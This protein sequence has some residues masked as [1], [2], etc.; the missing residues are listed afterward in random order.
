[1]SEASL[2]PS[3]WFYSPNKNLLH[4]STSLSSLPS[5]TL[6]SDMMTQLKNSPDDI[7]GFKVS[8]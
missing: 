4:T 5:H 1:M 6:G 2:D 8:V 7:K 3:S